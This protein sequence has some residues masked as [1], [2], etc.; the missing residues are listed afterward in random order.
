MSKI[1][2]KY[3]AR[4]FGEIYT[5]V[6]DEDDEFVLKVVHTVDAMMKEFAKAPVLMSDAKKIAVLTALKATEELLMLQQELQQDQI[7]TEKI[8]MLLNNDGD[9]TVR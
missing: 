6:S 4:I 2:K 8:L 7:Q 9:V 5:I 3:K 1:L